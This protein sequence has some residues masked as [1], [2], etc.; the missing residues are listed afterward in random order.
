MRARCLGA[1]SEKYASY[2]GRGITIDPR[3]GSFVNFLED[4][5]ERPEGTT[6]GRIDN[7]GPY[8]PENCRWETPSQQSSNQRKRTV[9]AETRKKMS[10]SMKKIRAEKFWSSRKEKP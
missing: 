10:A 5:G 6:L 2:G 1:G 4:M 9:S 3:W 7:D 8:S